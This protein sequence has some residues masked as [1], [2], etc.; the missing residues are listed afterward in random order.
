MNYNAERILLLQ[1]WPIENG[2]IHV[3]NTRWEHTGAARIH[4][5]KEELLKAPP[6]LHFRAPVV[7]PRQLCGTKFNPLWPHAQTQPPQERIDRAQASPT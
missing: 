6:A 5:S 3:P 1:Q 7:E 4:V 2:G